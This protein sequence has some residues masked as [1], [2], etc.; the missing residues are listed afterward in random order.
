MWLLSINA[1]FFNFY[2][3]IL[4]YQIQNPHILSTITVADNLRHPNYSLWLSGIREDP[5]SNSALYNPRRMIGRWTNLQAEWS[6]VKVVII[7]CLLCTVGLILTSVVFVQTHLS[8]SNQTWY[9]QNT[10]PHNIVTS[11]QL[12]LT[13]LLIFGIILITTLYVPCQW[14]VSRDI[15]IHFI[16]MGH[17]Q[18]SASL[19]DPRGWA[20][21]ATSSS[22]L[23]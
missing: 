9:H 3:K 17:F 13:E 7:S 18:D 1:F 6:A 20:Y 2:V 16:Q 10:H 21:G 4:L 15:W 5:P 23:K 12:S 8:Q 22:K 19:T 14:T 11:G